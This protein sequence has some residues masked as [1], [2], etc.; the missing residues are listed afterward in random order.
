[1]P[2]TE[3]IDLDFSRE[4]LPHTRRWVSVV[5][6]R[7]EF[8]LPDRPLR[9]LEVGAAQGRG[10]IS[11]QDLGHHVV[12]VEPWEPAIAVARALASDQGHEL[13]IRLGRAEDLPI[14]DG[15]VDLVLAFSVM[16]HV[17]DLD[18]SLREIYRVLA[19]GGVFWFNSASALCPKQEEIR[20]FPLFGWYPDR[21]KRRIMRW[22][23][24]HRRD[25]I[26]G[27]TAPA[28]HWWT[29]AKAER[30]L[31]GVGFAKVYDRWALRAPEEDAGARR[32]FVGLAKRHRSA[33]LVGDV[34][35]SSLAFAAVKPR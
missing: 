29:P 34:L 19:P 15:S 2:A 33:R 9:V 6:R 4:R 17:T 10:M 30:L 23:V 35:Q 20:G 16:E 8:L 25:L 13:D 27:T 5:L 12:G 11:L 18:A 26:G 7:L 14:E 24:D 28:M 22:A 21:V 1:M 31:T 3:T 32:R